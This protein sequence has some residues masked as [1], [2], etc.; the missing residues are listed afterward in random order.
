[1]RAK[2]KHICS[3]HKQNCKYTYI[4]IHQQ[5]FRVNLPMQANSTWKLNCANVLQETG[6]RYFGQFRT[7]SYLYS[8]PLPHIY[9]EPLP[10]EHIKPWLISLS[11]ARFLC[12]PAV[13]Y[14]Q[15]FAVCIYFFHTTC[16]CFLYL[17]RRAS[18]N[19]S[20]IK[21]R[22]KHNASNKSRTATAR[23]S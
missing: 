14:I 19:I 15:T 10:D 23:A 9:E 13:W 5:L 7:S 12:V 6:F 21:F 22:C 8:I 3:I 4:K 11:S 20:K 18:K 17:F 2:H 16:V 1:M